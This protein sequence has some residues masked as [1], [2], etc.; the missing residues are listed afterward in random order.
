MKFFRSL[1]VLLLLAATS[2]QAQTALRIA[3]DA[4][5]RK[6]AFIPDLNNNNASLS[7]V[8]GDDV[9]FEIGLFQNGR[10]YT[11]LYQLTN[12]TL[13]VFTAQNTT[14]G[15]LMAQSVTNSVGSPWWNTNCTLGGWTSNSLPDTNWQAEFYF[16]GMQTSIPLNG[17]ASQTYWLRLVALTTNNHTVTFMEGPITVYDGPYLQSYIAPGFPLSLAV[18]QFGDLMTAFTNFFNANSNLLNLSV[19]NNHGTGGGSGSP[20]TNLVAAGGNL[21]LNGALTNISSIT[22]GGGSGHPYFHS[23]LL[24]AG[25]DFSGLGWWTNVQTF[26]SVVTEAYGDS[27]TAPANNGT[28][29]RHTQ[30]ANAQ[31]TDPLEASEG[32]ILGGNN[33]YDGSGTVGYV[34]QLGWLGQ[35]D[36]VLPQ[37]AVSN[38][39]QNVILNYRTRFVVNSNSSSILVTLPPM[40]NW[41]RG[42]G[43][44]TNWSNGAHPLQADLLAWG[45]PGSSFIFLNGGPGGMTFVNQEHKPF[46]D[47]TTNKTLLPY[48]WA[49]V[50]G[51]S[52]AMHADIGGS[53]Y[54]ASIPPVG[55]GAG[56]TN[57]Q[58]ANIVGLASTNIAKNPQTLSADTIP[59]AP[60]FLVAG[61]DGSNH[62]VGG[63][64]PFSNNV[65][66]SNVVSQTNTSGQVVASQ[67][68]GFVGD[69]S[70]LTNSTGLPPGWTNIFA[71]GA[72]NDGVQILYAT[73][74]ASSTTVTVNTNV[75]SY[76]KPLGWGGFT[77]A[78]VGKNIEIQSHPASN[79]NS[80][81]GT[82]VAVVNGTNITV[83]VAP[84]NTSVLCDLRY[85]TDNTGPFTNA[86]NWSYTNGG[87]TIYVPPGTYFI[88]GAFQQLSNLAAGYRSQIIFPQP[89]RHTTF[90]TITFV[91]P[92]RPTPYNIPVLSTYT[93]LPQDGAILM[94][95]RQPPSASTFNTSIGI[96]NILSGGTFAGLGVVFKNLR[97]RGL[98]NPLNPLISMA[99]MGMF[100]MVDCSVDDGSDNTNQVWP[101]THST[102]AGVIMPN[103]NNIAD[104][105]LVGSCVVGH[106]IGA[107][108][109]EW[110]YVDN[111]TCNRCYQGVVSL[112]AP[113]GLWIGHLQLQGDNTEFDISTATAAVQIGGVMSIDG[114]HETGANTTSEDIYDPSNFGNGCGTVSETKSGSVDWILGSGIGGVGNGVFMHWQCP[115][116]NGYVTVPPRLWGTNAQTMGSVQAGL[117]QLTNF[118][119]V[120]NNNTN[121]GNGAF[122]LVLITNQASATFGSAVSGCAQFAASPA[123]SLARWNVSLTFGTTPLSGVLFTNAITPALASVPSVSMTALGNGQLLTNGIY[124]SSIT[125]T[126]VVVSVLTAPASSVTGTLQFQL[127]E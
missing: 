109:G 56:L 123:P 62:W 40:T 89:E 38:A 118:S 88:D 5:V 107:Q 29:I 8:R 21:N 46:D 63:T 17:Q 1:P 117:L 70:A 116:S 12:L 6:S 86:I 60:M 50:W 11:N 119:G 32:T 104:C 106:Y 15:P 10:F 76:F 120:V 16:P 39:T 80:T 67:P 102:G 37:F 61:P 78:D 127:Q 82:I 31:D 34:W 112:G 99:G 124:I 72:T 65:T 20:G 27:A 42:M 91:G 28:E 92:S 18:D 81:A 4:A 84:T 14:N 54:S 126:S 43:V 83:S 35:R 41:I 53:N 19:N 3:A 125:T 103:A 64:A 71:F 58:A 94:F 59:T 77:S 101:P 44:V 79:P 122:G 75:G 73:T 66:F 111:L 25:W 69:G 121:L 113:H 85:G 68:R 36:E 7:F 98:N 57:L 100:R 96:P 23:D 26:Y 105:Q 49:I 114:E 108:V 45:D 47:G 48:D 2:L 22:F 24:N 9:T 110:D 87:L 52:N 33:Y 13:Q 93:P 74:T 95:G 90:P 51:T 30:T 97:F 55:N 115:Y